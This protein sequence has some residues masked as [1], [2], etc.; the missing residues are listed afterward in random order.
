MNFDLSDEQQMMVDTVSKFVSNESPVE[1][2][3]KLRDTEAVWEKS[4]WQEM[5]EY[6]W[7]GVSF[8]RGARRL[9]WQLR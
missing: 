2:F 6:G 5:G 1:R 9:R 4:V 7:L 8:P 3:R